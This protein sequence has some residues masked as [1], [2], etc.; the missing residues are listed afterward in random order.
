[1]SWSL[2]ARQVC[3][4]NHSIIFEGTSS[5]THCPRHRLLR[6]RSLS[7]IRRNRHHLLLQPRPRRRRRLQTAIRLPI[8][9]IPRLRPRLQPRRRSNPRIQPRRPPQENH[10]RR[11]EPSRP[12]R[13]H[14]RR[15]P[16]I[17]QDCGREYRVH[18]AGWYGPVFRADAFGET[19]AGASEAW[20]GE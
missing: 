20:A 19:P 8:G 17:C 18:Q 13:F 4:H 1:M 15:R 5:N 3:S 12:R 2:A 11:R 7:R 10:F 14:S 9:Q 16:R 6:R